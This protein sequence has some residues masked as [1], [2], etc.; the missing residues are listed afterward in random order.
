MKRLNK[1]RE[2]KLQPVRIDFAINELAKLGIEPTEINQTSIKF[3]FK[4]SQVTLFA[5]SGWFTG[6][7]INDGRGINKLLAQIKLHN[8]IH[9]VN[10]NINL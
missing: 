4:D 10:S 3:I 8:K 9:E 1:E 2:Q 6:K 7:S 5:Y